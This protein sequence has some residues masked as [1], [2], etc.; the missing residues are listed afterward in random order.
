MYEGKVFATQ[1]VKSGEKVAAP[2]LAPAQ[3]GAWDFDF[4][5]KIEA[6]VTVFWK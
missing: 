6:N 1:T 3:S 4:G 5:T 2:V